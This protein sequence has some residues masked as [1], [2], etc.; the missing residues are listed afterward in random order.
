RMQ[1]I[2]ER[3]K[4]SADV[5]IFDTPPVT[6]VTDAALMAAKAEATIMVVQ[7]HRASRRMV[8]EG[9]EA[10]TKVNANMIGVVLN[11]VPGHVATPYYGRTRGDAD[12]GAGPSSV[13]LSMGRMTSNGPREVSDLG[14][15]QAAPD[16][17]TEPKTRRRRRPGSASPTPPRSSGD[18]A[19]GAK[20]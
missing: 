2:V 1:A 17:P 13:E 3:L 12:A 18:L 7:S 19:D 4:G 5:V 15:R 16:Q 20:S 8:A 14:D 10:L 11:N 9:L 6:A